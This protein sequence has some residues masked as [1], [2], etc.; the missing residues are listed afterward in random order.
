MYAVF[1]PGFIHCSKFLFK[2][3]CYWMIAVY[4]LVLRHNVHTEYVKYTVNCTVHH[5]TFTGTC[6]NYMYL[7]TNGQLTHNFNSLTY[8]PQPVNA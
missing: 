4:S 8:F 5:D 7:D 1:T 2:Q 6:F 3:L